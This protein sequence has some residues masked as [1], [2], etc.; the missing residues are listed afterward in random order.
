MIRFSC[1]WNG[2]EGTACP[3]YSTS[4]TGLCKWHSADKRIEDALIH[5]FT[6]GSRFSVRSIKEWL[7]MV[8][9]VLCSWYV[10][11]GLRHLATINTAA[12]RENDLQYGLLF[13]GMAACCSAAALALSRGTVDREWLTTGWQRLFWPS[14]ILL[15]GG[16]IL[17]LGFGESWGHNILAEAAIRWALPLAILVP[18]GIFF[19]AH[20]HYSGRDSTIL[21]LLGFVLIAGAGVV[22]IVLEI[23][24]QV[25]GYWDYVPTS[26]DLP[27]S[28]LAVV[29]IGN[30]LGYL[31]AAAD[32]FLAVWFG[33][34][35]FSPFRYREW[36][37]ALRTYGFPIVLAYG[38]FGYVVLDGQSGLIRQ[39]LLPLFGGYPLDVFYVIPFPPFPLIGY[40]GILLVLH[41]Y[42]FVKLPQIPVGPSSFG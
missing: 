18:S 33:W 11:I 4:E 3:R 13:L 15:A 19:V 7:P 40:L 39:A 26:K 21:L 27:R 6:S 29:Y 28:N 31:A 42:L 22:N 34:R 23:I 25:T 32:A 38:Y 37:N 24:F 2:T 30:S 36:A 35:L 12:G 20:H 8:F 10:E 16:W 41:Y 1:K 5:V 9:A 14:L 17:T